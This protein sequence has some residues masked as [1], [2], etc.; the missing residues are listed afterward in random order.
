MKITNKQL[1]EFYSV[2]EQTLYNWQKHEKKKHLY[3]ACKFYYFLF[4][5]DLLKQ[6]FKL[7]SF[8]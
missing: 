6:L 4:K 5:K 8:S 1:A 3:L 7:T 2:T